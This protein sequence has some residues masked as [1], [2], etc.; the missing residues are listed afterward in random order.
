MRIDFSIKF[1][2]FD[3]LMVKSVINSD[4]WKQLQIC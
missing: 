3:I 4:T 2:C 1:S